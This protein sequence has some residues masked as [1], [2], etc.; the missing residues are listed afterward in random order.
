MNY[1]ERPENFDITKLSNMNVVGSI[2]N[3]WFPRTVEDIQLAYKEAYDRSLVPY[4][5]GGGS[6]TL[7]GH[8][9][10]I[11]LVSDSCLEKTF[12][13]DE[14]TNELIVS[15]NHNINT[16]IQKASELGL[17]G[18]EFIVGLPAHLG[19]LICMN[20]GAYDKNISDFI[21]WIEVVDIEG[22]KRLYKKDIQFNYRK[23]SI[24]GFIVRACLRLID[25]TPPTPPYEGGLEL[26][27]LQR[28]D[29][30]GFNSH[31][32]LITA[33][34]EERKKKHPINY[35]NLGSFF[36]NP[37]E[38]PAWKLIDMAGLRGYSIGGAMVSTLH[39]NFLINTGNATFE[40]F[41]ALKDHI[42]STIYEK[43][44][45]TLET[46]VRIINE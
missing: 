3:I 15:A 19:G 7:I 27:P 31:Q 23:T 17:G 2:E 36:K 6:N 37:V 22:L 25:L 12:E 16:L 46:E 45:I 44:N 42:L 30:G 26:P 14:S 35:P 34:L 20:A 10:K 21:E 24:K 33:C 32:D 1:Y 29:K 38:E 41:I 5:I 39:T 28:G 4:P 8:L 40:D 13:Y 18:L 11:V 43:F 9:K